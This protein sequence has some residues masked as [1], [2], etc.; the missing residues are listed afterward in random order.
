[1]RNLNVQPHL[2]SRLSE[3][4]RAYHL[5]DALSTRPPVAYLKKVTQT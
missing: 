4:A 1:M 2:E 5:L 3:D